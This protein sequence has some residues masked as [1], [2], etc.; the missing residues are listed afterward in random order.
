MGW[1]K[2]KYIEELWAHED[3]FG[4]S[5]I[6]K[7]CDPEAGVDG[8]RYYGSFT[9]KY[10]TGK[11]DT[12]DI[13]FIPCQTLPVASEFT[14][15]GH[16][17]RSR[18]GFCLYVYSPSGTIYALTTF[19][20]EMAA[21][22][23]IEEDVLLR[24]V[25]L[26]A[27]YESM[28]YGSVLTEMPQE[29]PADDLLRVKAT[30]LMN[31]G[32]VPR[33][34]EPY[35]ERYY[36]NFSGYDIVFMSYKMN[37]TQTQTIA[38]ETFYYGT[39]FWLYAIKD[40]QIEVLQVVYKEG[41]VTQEDIVQLALIHRIT[42]YPGE[43]LDEIKHNV[44]DFDKWL[45]K[46]LTSE[47]ADPSK[48]N[49]EQFFLSAFREA[50][51]AVTASER[52]QI[53]EL[54]AHNPDYQELIDRLDITRLPV[55]RMNEVLQTCFGITLEDIDEAGFKDLHYLETTNCYYIIGGGASGTEDF[56]AQSIEVLHDGSI[57]VYYTANEDDTVYALTLVWKG[58][59]YKIHSNMR[60]PIQIQ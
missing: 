37:A 50:D 13:L 10:N 51:N 53:K 5:E 30:Y 39:Y 48:L 28:L 19:V 42:H 1:A 34:E 43:V 46:A 15:D 20:E 22:Y 38:G 12:F 21:A 4:D 45:N 27:K 49:L 9:W 3:L 35:G 52:A 11:S 18:N 60:V 58:D 31:I 59:G 8:I 47:Y 25:E 14:L 26:H 17:F 23:T 40:W 57:C 6:M 56:Q 24:A 44:Q 54:F 16:T 36:G 32:S 7:F 29:D 41:L 55:E 2:V 33:F